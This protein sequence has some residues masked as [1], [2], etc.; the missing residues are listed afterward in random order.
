[1]RLVR[2]CRIAAF[3]LSAAVLAAGL[4]VLAGWT[5]G[6][7]VLTTFG[8][9]GVAMNPLTAACLVLLAAAL[10]LMLP[11]ST[12]GVER[13]TARG[14]A[15]AVLTAA[16]VKL[17]TLGS[18]N[19][20]DAWLFAASIDAITPVNRM[21]PNTALIMA[22]LGVAILLIDVTVRGGRR[23]AALLAF[24]A[25]LITLVVL[26]GFVFNV[27]DLYGWGAYIPMARSTALAL[28]GLE[29]AI[30][31]GRVEHGVTRIFV[32]SGSGGVAARRLLPAAVLLPL[33]IGYARLR[34]ERLGLYSSEFGVVLFS[35][36]MVAAL[37]LLVAWTAADAD[38]IDAA[39]ADVESR[40]Q[41][42][43]RHVPFGI[44]VLD[45]DGRVQLCNDAFVELFHYRAS[46]LMGQQIDQLIAPRDDEGETAWL[47]TRGVSGESVR[48]VT[49]RRRRDGELVEVEVFVVPLES[50]GRPAGAY[51]L[52]RDLTEQRRADARRR[53][54]PAT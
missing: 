24:L 30:L 19:G 41:S 50:H 5:F 23:P 17:G 22:V 45:L 13:W 16:L 32:S 12:S 48:R 1:M 25:I 33:V 52:Y 7:P 40:L 31:A 15:A 44:V 28:V 10:Q 39:R 11:G 54:G 18:L 34:G 51:G 29:L 21:A 42:L 35:L 38:R 20:P 9:R 43:I 47:T 2:G 3:A 8:A 4:I 6:L 27:E 36:A 14:M 26:V 49:V 46:E 37:T 53:S